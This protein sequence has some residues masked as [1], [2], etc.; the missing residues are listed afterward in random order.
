[1]AINYSIVAMKNPQRS[2]PATTMD[3]AEQ[4]T[5]EET[6]GTAL[7]EGTAH[8]DSVTTRGDMSLP[9]GTLIL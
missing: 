5:S 7:P 9:G 4:R 2:Y 8:A 6:G 3:T 1:M